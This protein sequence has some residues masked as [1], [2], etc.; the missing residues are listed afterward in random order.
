M[1]IIAGTSVGIMFSM[2]RIYTNSIWY[3]VI[4]HTLWDLL[5]A[6]SPNNFLV[7]G[8]NPTISDSFYSYKLSDSSLFLFG[9]D[10][11]IETS[12]IAIMIYLSVSLILF[13]KIKNIEI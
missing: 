12:I 1:L 2:I 10:Y 4:V 9:G 8:P 3:G 6:T 7:I 11:G 5:A 13:V